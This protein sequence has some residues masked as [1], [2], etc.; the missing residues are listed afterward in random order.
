MRLGPRSRGS[1]KALRLLHAHLSPPIPAAAAAATVPVSPLP[2]RGAPSPGH[3]AR[4][5]SMAS[6]RPGP[7]EAAFRVC[8]PGS[9][10]GP[11]PGPHVL[12]VAVGGASGVLGVG[13]SSSSGTQEAAAPL[14]PGPDPPGLP[15]SAPAQAPSG[16]PLPSA[17]GGRDGALLTHFLSFLE[18]SA[19]PGA[20]GAGQPEAESGHGESGPRPAGS[21]WEGGRGSLGPL[22]TCPAGLCGPRPGSHVPSCRQ[23]RAG[24]RRA[25]V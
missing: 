20:G 1:G 5:R 8:A 10:V 17:R 22:L 11:W 16:P 13:P 12:L 23:E 4:G 3:S 21:V 2:L 19:V 7:R 9:G 15:G 25:E 14:P 18:G 24:S 6:E